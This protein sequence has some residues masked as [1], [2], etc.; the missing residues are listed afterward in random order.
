MITLRML[1]ASLVMLLSAPLVAA[2]IEMDGVHWELSGENTVFT[3]Y[4]GRRAIKIDGGFAELKNTN[5]HNGVIEFDVAMPETRG[6]AGIN[7]RRND[8]MAENFYMR[9]HQSGN[10]D[11]NQYTPIFNNT[12]AWQIYYGPRYAQPTK[13]RFDTWMP[14]K[15]VVKGNKMDVYIDSEEPVFHVDNL[16]QGDTE[17]SIRL[18]GFLSE[19][20][21]SNVSITHTDDVT[22]V[23]KAEEQPELPEGL[24][25]SFKVATKAVAGKLVEGKTMLD[26]SLLDGQTWVDLAVEQNGVANLSRVSAR[27]RKDNTLLAKLSVSAEEAKTLLLKYG[28]SDRVTIFLN[29][30][31]LVYGNDSFLSRDYRFLGTIGSHAGVFLPLKKGDNEL[32]F[33]VTEAF[34]GWGLMAIVEDQTNVAIR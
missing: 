23:G 8:V 11:A 27:D 18:T 3:D 21:F 33:A 29:G 25:K 34:G 19:Y 22:L 24:I 30:K 16:L 4:L 9:S 32:I 6:F 15:L 26:P 12:A 28:F 7:F 31:A 10:P 1:G 5:F 2:Q 14:V 13:Y 17:G 20:H